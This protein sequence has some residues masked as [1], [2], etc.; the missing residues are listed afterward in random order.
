[1]GKF[2]RVKVLFLPYEVATV[3]ALDP[4]GLESGAR[5]AGVVYIRPFGE[6][7]R[8]G[9]FAALEKIQIR[10]KL[11]RNPDL[12]W[13]AIF[14]HI[15]D[16]ELHSLYTEGRMLGST[17][18]GMIDGKSLSLNSALTDWFEKTFP[19]IMRAA[20]DGQFRVDSPKRR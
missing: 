6:S 10:E 16:R 3:A 13:G 2:Y 5:H 14:Y 7:I 1:A 11:D 12:R 18:R 15:G 4:E 17:Q 20:A 9:L 19:E 8:K